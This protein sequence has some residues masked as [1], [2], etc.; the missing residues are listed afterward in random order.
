MAVFYANSKQEV[1]EVEEVKEIKDFGVKRP[2]GNLVSTQ[3]EGHDMVRL[4][5]PQVSCLY[6]PK[7]G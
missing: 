3:K 1:R 4:R 2:D 6:N 7:T 5:S